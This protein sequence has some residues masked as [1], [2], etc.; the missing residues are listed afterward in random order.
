ME[1][2]AEHIRPNFD[3][4]VVYCEYYNNYHRLRIKTDRTNKYGKVYIMLTRVNTPIHFYLYFENGLYFRYD[5]TVNKQTEINDVLETIITKFYAKVMNRIYYLEKRETM[6][7]PMFLLYL[8]KFLTECEYNKQQTKEVMLSFYKEI[9]P[10]NKFMLFKIM[11]K[12]MGYMAESDFVS[13][14]VKGLK[15]LS[16]WFWDL[17]AVVGYTPKLNLE[18]YRVHNSKSVGIK[19]ISYEDFLK[20]IEGFSQDDIIAMLSN[21]G[22]EMQD[23]YYMPSYDLKRKLYV[24]M[25][26][27]RR[28]AEK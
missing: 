20:T 16:S 4:E 3:F 9:K 27:H 28:S 5:E 19:R 13:Q 1:L 18:T 21:Y 2:N 10:Y 8:D 26:R 7:L 17:P 24:V 11:S 22:I 25:H 12:P 14:Y 15:R 6:G 23:K